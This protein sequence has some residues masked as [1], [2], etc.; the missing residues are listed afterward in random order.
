MKAR[1]FTT[2]NIIIQITVGLFLI[3]T[4]TSS[5]YYD[6]EEILY[7][8]S[9]CDTATVTY[10]SS[11]VPI[12]VSNCTSCHAGNTPSAGIKLDTHADVKI[13]VAN[14]KLWG[15]VSHTASYSPMPKSGSK[16][17]DCNLTKIKKWIDAGA[18]NN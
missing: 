4:S 3:T 17:S 10:S 11:V 16:M 18:P 2:T 14:G 8:Q 5:C 13:Q 15:S 7:P 9:A 1:L 6:K 12:L